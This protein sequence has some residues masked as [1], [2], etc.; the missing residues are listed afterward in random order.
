M[1]VL[2][3]L[4]LPL[5]LFRLEP[6]VAKQSVLKVARLSPKILALGHGAPIVA[7]TRNATTRIAKRFG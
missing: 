7:K 2:P 3:Q 4:T 5:A 6:E 1:H